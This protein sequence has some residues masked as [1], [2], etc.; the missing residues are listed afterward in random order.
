LD[1][2]PLYHAYNFNMPSTNAVDPNSANTTVVG[3]PV[4][5]AVNTTVVGTLIATFACPSDDPPELVNDPTGAVLGSQYI[6]LNARRSNYVLCSSHYIDSDSPWSV[7][8][9]PRD[10]GIFQTDSSTKLD[11]VK[12]GVSNTC[13]VGEAHQHKVDSSYGPYWGSGCWSSTHGVVYPP[14]DPKAPD[15]MPNAQATAASSSQPNPQKLQNLWAMGSRH[16]GGLNMLFADGSVKF[17]KDSINNTIWYD[18]Q[19]VRG[20]EVIGSD[21]Y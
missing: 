13:M 9:R 10:L 6:R 4:G 16:S 21:S 19:T 15:Y 20:Q 12:D 17:I 5:A 18:L 14:T 3:L 2:A 8:G 11:D 7:P 1:Q